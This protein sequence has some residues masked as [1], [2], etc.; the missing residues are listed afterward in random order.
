MR[1]L[2]AIL[3]LASLGCREADQRPQAIESHDTCAHCKMAISQPRYAAQIVDKDGTAYKF[4]DIGCMTNFARQ[5][6]LAPPSGAK[7]YVIDYASAEWLDAEKA[8]F[9]RSEAIDSPMASGLAG[10]RDASAAQSFTK[11]NPGQILT[12]K[13]VMESDSKRG[14]VAH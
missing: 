3:L 2:V 13:D 11:S 4:D 1:T 12:L 10:F 9:V 14:L 6:K 8:V 5:R 7:I